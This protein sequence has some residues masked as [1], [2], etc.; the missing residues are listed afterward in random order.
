[1]EFED[2]CSEEYFRTS[3]LEKLMNSENDSKLCLYK[4]YLHKVSPKDTLKETIIRILQK[5]MEKKLGSGLP[6][7]NL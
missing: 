3:V 7:V 4:T 6:E 1:M 5:P 2:S